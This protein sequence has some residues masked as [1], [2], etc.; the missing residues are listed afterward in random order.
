MKGGPRLDPAPQ[1]E[2]QP[3]KG[4]VGGVG[5]P[6]QTHEAV[7]NQPVAAQEDTNCFAAGM[8]LLTPDGGKLIETF[9]A[10]D[11]ILSRSEFDPTGPLEVKQVE[12][13]FVR[14]GL[15]RSVWVEGREIRTTA[16]HPFYV[17][18]KGWVKAEFLEVGDW[19]SSHDGHWRPVERVEDTRQ[20]ETVYNLR[21][22]DSHTYFVG[23]QEWSFSVWRIMQTT[24]RLNFLRANGW[25]STG[26]SQVVAQSNFSKLRAWGEADREQA[27]QM[28]GRLNEAAKVAT[29]TPHPLRTQS[30]GDWPTCGHRANHR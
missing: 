20:V 11:R 5:K 1:Q 15:I 27:E 26:R 6:P 23:C 19:L 3:I 7:Q 14:V 2:P 30:L 10:G 21:V 18:N 4:G 8:P 25:S 22:A 13:V 29:P 16:E 9:Q 28:A 12:E 17:S 24:F